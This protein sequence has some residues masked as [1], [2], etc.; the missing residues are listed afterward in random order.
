MVDE[1]L[2]IGAATWSA[3]RGARSLGSWPSS[4]DHLKALS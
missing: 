3:A 1:I 2:L 4:S